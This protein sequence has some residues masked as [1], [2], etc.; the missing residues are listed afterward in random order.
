MKNN[1]LQTIRQIYPIFL[2]INASG[3][4]NGIWSNEL[5]RMLLSLIT[6]LKKLDANNATYEI[7]IGILRYSDEVNWLNGNHL[8]PISVYKWD[9]I[10]FQGAT[11]TGAAFQELEYRLSRK[12]FFNSPIPHKLPYIVFVSGSIP[13]DN[14][15]EPFILLSENKWFISAQRTSIAIGEQAPIELMRV[16]S[17]SENNL[18]TINTPDGINSIAETLFADIFNF[19]QQFKPFSSYEENPKIYE[20]CL[21]DSLI[22]YYDLDEWE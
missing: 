14:W 12:T 6:K 3:N 17:S 4:M 8:V 5:N 10:L 2:I 20:E 19:H 21:I 22:E 13:T 16:F 7:R 1:D 18:I 15:K 11:S 9:N